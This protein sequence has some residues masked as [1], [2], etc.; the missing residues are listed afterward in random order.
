MKD[1]CITCKAGTDMER[2]VKVGDFG[3]CILHAVLI[4]LSSDSHMERLV[5][6]FENEP[7]LLLRIEYLCGNKDCGTKEALQ[8]SLLTRCDVTYRRSEVVL[9]VSAAHVARAIHAR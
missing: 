1:P 9:N 4:P 6:E 8:S 5:L 2:W 7:F 3:P